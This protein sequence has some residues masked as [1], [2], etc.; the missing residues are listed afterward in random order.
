MNRIGGLADL[1]FVLGVALV[2]LVVVA[3]IVGADCGGAQ[4][5]C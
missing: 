5:N 3:R 1:L 2:L 4:W